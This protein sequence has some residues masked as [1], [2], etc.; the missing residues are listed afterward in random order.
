[1]AKK[2]IPAHMI[3][4]LWKFKKDEVDGWIRDGKAGE[5]SN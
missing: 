2:G 5:N 1:M 4:R 3:G